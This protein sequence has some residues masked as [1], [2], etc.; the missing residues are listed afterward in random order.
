MNYLYNLKR[1]GY[2]ETLALLHYHLDLLEKEN[3]DPAKTYLFFDHYYNNQWLD[4]EPKPD[5]CV[6]DV[7]REQGKVVGVHGKAYK[8]SGRLLYDGLYFNRRYNGMGRLYLC[9]QDYYEGTFKD[10]KKEGEFSLFNERLKLRTDHFLND[11]LQGESTEYFNNNMIRSKFHYIDG[12]KH[13]AAEIR[14]GSGGLIFKGSYV[15]DNKSGTAY[16]FLGPNVA[17]KCEYDMGNLKSKTLV[18]IPLKFKDSPL[19]PIY[20][21][22]YRE[23]KVVLP[24]ATECGSIFKQKDESNPLSIHSQTQEVNSVPVRICRIAAAV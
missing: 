11:R 19:E 22:E 17:Y 6:L 12:K 10:G 4:H 23:L 1:N 9:N 18:Y 20:D 5:E 15:N 3:N 7:I 13:G 16:E 24:I 14:N 8:R 2:N 21:D